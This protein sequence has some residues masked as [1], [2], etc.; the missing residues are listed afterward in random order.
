MPTLTWPNKTPN[1]RRNLDIQ[2]SSFPN[3]I[4]DR[5]HVAAAK[6][7]VYFMHMLWNKRTEMP[8]YCTN[9][10]TTHCNTVCYCMPEQYLQVIQ[11]LEQNVTDLSTK[12]SKLAPIF[13]KLLHTPQIQVTPRSSLRR[14][15][16]YCSML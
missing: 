12:Y 7:H 15:M 11:T 4:H 8:L 3:K 9:I 14:N 6:K 16:A 5:Q 13:T 10:S 2:L 1:L